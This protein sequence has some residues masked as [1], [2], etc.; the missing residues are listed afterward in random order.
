MV[1]AAVDRVVAVAAVDGVVACAS[2]NRVVA[3]AAGECVGVVTADQKEQDALAFIARADTALYRAKRA[4]R[5][6]VQIGDTDA[7]VPMRL[8]SAAG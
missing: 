2:R 8:V 3:E 7:V 4:G 1:G 6:R 5:N